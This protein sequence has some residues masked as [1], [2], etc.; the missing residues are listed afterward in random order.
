[1]ESRLDE[2]EKV[3]V[4]G[5]GLGDAPAALEPLPDAAHATY[6]L[7]DGRTMMTGEGST[8]RDMILSQYRP[9]RRAI[10][11]VLAQAVHACKKPDL[12]RAAKH[13]GLVDDAQLA[14]DTVFD[15]LCDVALFEPN[16]RGRRVFDG[17]LR[18]RLAALD[19]AEQDIARRMGGAFVS[20]FRVAERHAQAGLWLE[21]LLAAGRRLW[22]LDDSVEATAPEGL[23]I[24]M[25]LF[26]AGPFYAGF[27]IIVEPRDD[28]VAFCTRAAVR[29]DRL[30]IRHSLAAA[31]YADDIQA[32]SLPVIEEVAVPDAIVEALMRQARL[33]KDLPVA[34]ARR[35]RRQP[36]RGAISACISVAPSTPAHPTRFDRVTF[37]AGAFARIPLSGRA[38]PFPVA[39]RA[40]PGYR[41]FAV[42]TRS[43]AG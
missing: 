11:G 35:M 38:L 29:G 30:P 2:I 28:L 3:V 24:G 25:R 16:Q 32:R 42:S 6:L 19:P 31:L 43:S 37:A 27:G 12:D 4:P 1:M 10:Q 17:F 22:L 7:A 23:V 41:G 36:K 14:D 33:P 40:K 20:I 34:G 5:A 21:D 26:E 18:D 9:I 8:T 13:L 39:L 15:M